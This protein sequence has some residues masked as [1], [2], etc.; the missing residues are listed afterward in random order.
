MSAPPPTPTETRLI[1][2]EQLVRD[3]RARIAVLERAL[4]VRGEHPVDQ[5][6]VQRKVTYD[7]QA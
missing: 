7:W 3:L 5:S 6:V 1:A 2:L 4:D